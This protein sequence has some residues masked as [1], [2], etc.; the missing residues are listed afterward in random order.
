MMIRESHRYGQQFITLDQKDSPAHAIATNHLV[1]SLYDPIA[2]RKLAELADVL[3][4]EIEH[5]DVETL[6]QLELEGKAIFPKPGVLQII[7]DKCLQKEFY[8]RNQIPTAPFIPINVPDENPEMI[9]LP[10]SSTWHI[11]KTR[12]GGY[13]GKGVARWHIGEPFPFDGACIIEQP[14]DI[15]KEL[16]VTVCVGQDGSVKSYPVVE[17]V[18]DPTANLVDYLISP[19]SISADVAQKATDIACKTAAAFQSPGLFAVEMFLNRTGEI[20]VNE[21]APRLHNSGHHTIEANVTSQFEQLTRILLG[22]PLG[23]TTSLRHGAMLN[24]LGAQHFSGP[25]KLEG[26][27][28]LAAMP[29]VFVHLYGKHQS[30]PWRKLGHVTVL[31]DSPAM[32]HERIKRI[33]EILR[34]V[35]A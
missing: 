16:A 3:T 25:W 22:W 18:F 31:A 21:T 19:A 14:A 11:V 20:W 15:E 30:K 26:W 29:G 24:I 27:D 2:L 6:K 13:D 10:W 4:F 7:Q 12:T 5:V 1:G 23:D 9:H 32:C 8:E 17:M 33:R 28:N 35:P 34:V